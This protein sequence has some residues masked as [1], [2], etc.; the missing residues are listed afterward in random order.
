[1]SFLKT[2]LALK[3]VVFPFIRIVCHFFGD[4][5]KYPRHIGLIMDGNRRFAA[6]SGLASEMHGHSRG[7]EKL[8]EVLEWILQ[9][10]SDCCSEV[11]V[12]AFSTENFSRSAA[13]VS[14]LMELF[15]LKVKCFL[16][17]FT[18]TFFQLKELMLPG[19]LEFLREN[20]VKIGV[21]G[22]LSLLPLEIQDLAAA[23]HQETSRY[24][25]LRTL[26]VLM[27]YSSEAELASCRDGTAQQGIFEDH[28]WVKSDVDLLIRT[29]GE[30]RL[31]GF[32][33]YQVNQRTMIKFLCK[34]WPELSVQDLLCCLF[35]FFLFSYFRR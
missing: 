8:K 33:C 3:Y 23:V 34:F 5:I 28:L 24:E 6:A 4:L 9:L 29:S 32:L 7:F 20:R 15:E 18:C 27:A 14:G 30:V 31:S 10:P 16:A 13:E 19:N 22:Q 21:L 11:S 1:M 26:N 17:L 12:F 25:P 2:S 35:E